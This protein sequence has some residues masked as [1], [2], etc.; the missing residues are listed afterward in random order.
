MFKKEHGI[1]LV[2]DRDEKK[3]K[4][5][6]TISIGKD[7]RKKK[8]IF[9]D[10][11]VADGL[12]SPFYVVYET[13]NDPDAE[14]KLC[15]D[16]WAGTCRDSD[17]AFC[18]CSCWLAANHWCGCLATSDACCCC[19]TSDLESKG[20]VFKSV[21]RRRINEKNVGFSGKIWWVLFEMPSVSYIFGKS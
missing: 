17:R 21:F 8:I 20:F 11:N 14:S 7:T 19:W 18:C 12:R 9:C 4:S 3:K 10:R 16:G 5:I 2:I 6:K 15:T 1:L 13:E